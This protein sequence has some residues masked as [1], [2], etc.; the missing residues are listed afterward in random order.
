M[1]E[2]G[3]TISNHW[4][5]L[6]N[7]SVL[8][9][10]ICYE[11][12]QVAPKM[13]QFKGQLINKNFNSGKLAVTSATALYPGQHL[14]ANPYTAAIDI[15]Q[16]E[17][18]TSMD[19]VVYLYNTGKFTQ[20]RDSSSTK[21]GEM[22][23]S[24]VAAPKNTAGLAGIPR[25]VPSMNSILVRATTS[26]NQ[27][28]ININYNNVVMGNTEKQ[29]I[30]NVSF[31]ENISSTVIE[32]KGT[33]S[34]DKIWLFSKDEFTR[35]YDN[36]YDGRKILGSALNP[37]I[38]AVEEDGNYQINAVDNIHNTLLAF[39]AGQ[40]TEYT[41]TF[42]HENSNGKYGKIYLHDLETNLVVD[43]TQ[44]NSEYLFEAQSTPLPSNRFKIITQ[45]AQEI[46]NNAENQISVFNLSNTIYIQNTGNE[47]GNA[48]VYDLA[49]RKITSQKITA[50]SVITVNVNKQQVYIIKIETLTEKIIKKLSIF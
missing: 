30:K 34:Q 31:E 32:V 40:D 21:I 9:P 48:Y 16:I 46:S 18:G 33:S 37:Q 39:Q 49:G 13:Y 38:Y 28:Y 4:Q 6:N 15:R 8:Q 1:L 3:T 29:R 2:T 12:C 24:Y 47:H 36:G 50:N 22:P 11:L 17:F 45:S 27:A 35:N 19:A 14:F 10:F 26:D 25:Q 44:D 43:V 23:G 20:W 42:S 7:N 5:L 41:M